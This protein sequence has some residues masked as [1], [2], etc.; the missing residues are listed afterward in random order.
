[1]EPVQIAMREHYEIAEKTIPRTRSFHHF[2]PLGD[3]KIGIK[4]AYWQ[5]HYDL[6]FNFGQQHN[7][8]RPTP[9]SYV[10]CIPGVSE[11]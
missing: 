8:I 4:R 1:M 9:Q 3:N 7:I 6:V 11:K 10:M 5:D 2:I